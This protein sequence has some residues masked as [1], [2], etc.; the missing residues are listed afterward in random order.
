MAESN[1][2]DFKRKQQLVEALLACTC[3]QTSQSR[4][5]IKGEL[6]SQIS[7]RIENF[8]NARQD[9]T[10]IVNAC[11]NFP[12][13]LAELMSVV[14]FHEGPTLA[15]QK[16][17]AV[18][19]GSPASN[20][21][22][23]SAQIKTPDA[24]PPAPELAKPAAQIPAP[25]VAPLVTP[26]A[27]APAV[28][29]AVPPAADQPP[30]NPIVSP[31][32]NVASDAASNKNKMILFGVLLVVVLLLSVVFAGGWLRFG[33]N[34]QFSFVM[35]VILGLLA[36]VTCYGLLASTGE[37]DGEQHSVKFKLTGAIVA[38]VAVAGGGALYEKYVPHRA[39]TFAQRVNFYSAQPTQ[40]EKLN[41]AATL[42]FGYERRTETLRETGTLLYL[43][44]P[45]EWLGQVA[46]LDLDSPDFELAPL[47][48]SPI[49]TDGEPV[50]F[51]VARKRKF[52]VP[53]EAQLDLRWQLGSYRQ[54]P[55]GNAKQLALQV[56]VTSQS[57]AVIPLDTDGTLTI[58]SG[59]GAPLFTL[60]LTM[61]EIVHLSARAAQLIRLEGFMTK[62]QYG[63]VAKGTRA[64]LKLE[65][66]QMIERNS[67][68]FQTEFTFNKQTIPAVR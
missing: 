12:D 45:S 13:G 38:L 20:A 53:A 3:L 8:D 9:V 26:P 52:A 67:R 14:E 6:R 41:G 37:I 66:D 51:K 24:R 23:T 22:Q 65:Y 43:G 16:L 33:L 49:F 54:K 1:G 36:A 68:A 30:A 17:Q 29:P 4:N 15:W 42:A 39:A 44:I 55:N 59:T 50:A 60:G 5:Q 46:R 62:A 21:G 61:P 11:L 25:E 27:L 10:S 48:R 32:A 57:D 18:Y 58:L 31:P 35:Y 64:V 56:R 28:K 63:T 40:L 34:G 19:Q 47:E 7:Q 2:W